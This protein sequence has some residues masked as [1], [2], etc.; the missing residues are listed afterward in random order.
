MGVTPPVVGSAGYLLYKAGMIGQRG[1]D[2]A[3]A[4]VGLTA[5]EFLVL[6]F[7]SEAALSQ[8][9]VARRLA[10]DPT[11][12][13]GV[14]DDL[15]GRGLLRRDKDPA[16]RRRYLLTVTAEGFALL[17][18]ARTTATNA[19]R[20]FLDPLDDDQRAQLEELLLVLMT[21][22]LPWLQQ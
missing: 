4:S 17:A 21:P 12:M 3:F 1:F 13:V 19:E 2:D 9:D 6:S 5:R 8:Q 10:I 16:D 14:V 22:K 20:A 15:E 11:L 7:A 18:T